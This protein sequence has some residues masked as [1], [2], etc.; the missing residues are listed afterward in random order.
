MRACVRCS[1]DISGRHGTA[2]YCGA[3]GVLATFTSFAC[4]RKVRKAIAAGLL[5]T[6]Q[7][8]RCEDCQRPARVYDHRDYSKPLQVAAVC[9]RCNVLRGPA[10][11]PAVTRT[12]AKA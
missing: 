11:W 6:P 1:A 5:P 8:Q 9:G 7:S 10:L 2:R 4:S 3:C 12:K